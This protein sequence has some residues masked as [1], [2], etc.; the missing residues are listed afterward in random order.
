MAKRLLKT[1]LLPL[2]VMATAFAFI[3][4]DGSNPPDVKYKVTYEIGANA[5]GTAPTE[6]DKAFGEKFI[7][8]SADGITCDGAT[9]TG[10]SDGNITYQ[11]GAEYT[12]PSKAV[13]FTAQWQPNGTV[14]PTTYNVTYKYGVAGEDVV[15]NNQTAENYA[16][17]AP[18]KYRYTGN[19]E[20]LKIFAGWKVEGDDT[21]YL[22]NSKLT[23]T[24]DTVFTAQWIDY[25]DD[26]EWRD[27]TY[28]LQLKL[29][30]DKVGALILYLGG[31][32]E[33]PNLSWTYFTYTVSGT[34]ITVTPVAGN[35]A[36]G[37]L[38]DG[39]L[40]IRVTVGMA[41]YEFKSEQA[42]PEFTFGLNGG[43]GTVPTLTV[44][45]EMYDESEN[46]YVVTM[47]ENTITPPAG[48][49]F[50]EWLVTASSGGE[51]RV[52]AGDSYSAAA[53]NTYT[54]TPVWKNVRV[55]LPEGTVFYGDCTLP[56]DRTGKGGET[57]ISVII[58]NSDAQN[59]KVYY[60]LVGDDTYQTSTKGSNAY[61]SYKPDVYGPDAL[62][63]GEYFI[64]SVTYIMLVKSD[65]TA[66]YLCDNDDNLLDDGEFTTTPAPCTVTYNK[67]DDATGTMDA[68]TADV[69]DYTLADCT[70]TKAGWTFLG[71]KDESL[72]F[73]D[74][75]VVT[76]AGEEVS[77]YKNKSYIAV[78]AKIYT[79]A[80]DST[81]TIALRDDEY[82]LW[83]ANGE[84]VYAA[85]TTVSENMIMVTNGMAYTAYININGNTYTALDELVT[86]TFTT[87]DGN[88]TLTFDGLGKAMLGTHEGTYEKITESHGMFGDVLIGVKLTFG[89]NLYECEFVF[90]TDENPY[91]NATITVGGVDY[92]FNPYTEYTV[93]F[94]V[95]DGATGTA[96]AQKTVEVIGGGEGKVTL[97]DAE[98]DMQKTGYGFMGWQ[99]KNGDGDLYY[100]NEKC[101]ITGNTT[102]VAVWG[103]I[104]TYNVTY[105]IGEDVT[106]TV[107]TA[108]TV[109]TEAG[110]TT[111]AVELNNGAGLT[112]E[113]YKFEGWKKKNSDGTLSDTVYKGYAPVSAD[114]TFVAYFEEISASTD[115]LANYLGGSGQAN[116]VKYGYTDKPLNSDETVNTN[117]T[118]DL[119]NSTGAARNY[120]RLEVYWLGGNAYFA[121]VYG[122]ASSNSLKS[123]ILD[124]NGN[125]Q[126]EADNPDNETGYYTATT[127]NQ[128]KVS[129]TFS[130]DVNANN[131]RTVTITVTVGGQE[132]TVTWTEITD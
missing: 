131:L 87:A 71:W 13:T 4:C 82:V 63:Y 66:L 76:A 73:Y 85:W 100:A 115:K 67:P 29:L 7:I 15:K 44:T 55:P 117:V 28:E 97:P 121:L 111:A 53:G 127:T 5:D 72:G 75:P 14:A 69:G 89:S 106:G 9:F 128:A 37:T 11:A 129:V 43:T 130:F 86:Y 35:P 18:T 109:D 104:K 36:T 3:A 96:P 94:E 33:N 114:T 107:P 51:R 58:D 38:E 99:I 39:E 52:A 78:F 120:Y 95:G 68:V 108:T 22:P 59:I 8:K 65:F 6:T 19:D 31:D 81:V 56:V 1:M 80:N 49:Q 105:E 61:E 74:D 2:T 132:E 124:S 40:T 25:D 32:E 92:V 64:G 50:K 118:F 47:P 79:N 90:D 103:E 21:V 122:T 60:K 26:N 30:T 84:M 125:K 70:Y 113:G 16:V 102:F 17:E 123:N 54:V 10:W 62:Y 88:T 101:T 34:A 77:L 48:K 46:C 45:E 20:Y 93:T 126:A 12:M 112:K 42:L 41:T 83:N 110:M 91:I 27:T 23:L 116:A 119:P 24:G 98:Q 57:V